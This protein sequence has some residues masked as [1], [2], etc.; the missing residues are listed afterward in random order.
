MVIEHIRTLVAA[1][2]HAEASDADLLARFEAGHDE[3]AFAVL[4]KRHGSMVLR[5]ARRVLGREQDAEDVFQATFLLLARNAASIRKRAS[6]GSWL[7]GVAHRL[8]ERVRSQNTRR[9]RDE[10]R[11]ARRRAAESPAG[12]AWTELQEVLDGVLARLPEKYRTPLVLCYLEGETQEE[13]ALRLNRP[14]GTVR[15]WLARG[16]TMLRNRLARQGVT[17]S[18]EAVGAALL[19]SAACARA[20]EMPISLVQPTLNAALRIAGGKAV[21]ELVSAEVAGLVKGGIASMLT[22]KFK[23]G[24]ALCLALAVLAAGAGLAA[25][26]TIQEKPVEAQADNRSERADPPAADGVMRVVVLDPQGKPLPGA[27]VHSGIWTEEKDFK[28]NH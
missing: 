20:I 15:S 27:M 3:S 13:V 7:H 18:V 21:G 2:A 24:V 23:T 1:Q 8:A 22:S 11:A 28:S 19:G 26:Q 12:H 16:R 10:H 17:L 6:V 5:V 9:K 4:L 25:R 14:L